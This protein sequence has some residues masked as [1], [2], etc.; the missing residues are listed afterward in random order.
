[1]GGRTFLILAEAIR[2]DGERLHRDSACTALGASAS[3]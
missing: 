3:A 1:M 2:D